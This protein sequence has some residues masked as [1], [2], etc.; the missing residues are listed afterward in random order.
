MRK[1]VLLGLLVFAALAFAGSATSQAPK[2]AVQTGSDIVLNDDAEKLQEV[3]TPAATER[4]FRV[5]GPQA[6]IA[7]STPPLGTEKFWYSRNG[8]ALVR[9]RLFRLRSVTA[10]SEVWVSTVLDFKAG[11]CR[12]D[13]DR[14]VLT[15]TQVNYLADQFENNIYPKEAAE[16]SVAPNRDGTLARRGQ[17][18]TPFSLTGGDNY[19]AGDGDKIVI[20]VDNVR[21]DNY[22]D[23]SNS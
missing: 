16:F 6:S 3:G 15:D 7:V 5:L 9:D 1:G 10:H 12:N 13:G 17:P 14:N 4:P 8:N 23:L 11:D 19:Y 22:N 20:L 18:G 21:D 2:P